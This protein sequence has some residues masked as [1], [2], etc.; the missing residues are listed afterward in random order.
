ML[1]KVRNR[2]GL[3]AAVEPYDASSQGRFHMVRVEYTEADG[4]P[5]DNV[6]WEVEQDTTLLEPHALPKVSGDPAMT[7][8]E[9]DAFQHAIRWSALT[10]FLDPAGSG[11]RSETIFASPFFGAVQVDD[12]QLVPLAK[13][14]TMP[15]VSLLLAD[16]VGLGKTIEAGLILTE[17]LLRRRVRRVLILT[18]ASLTQQWQQEM[19]DRFA[20]SF[21]IID[22]NET[23][24]LQK[25]LG[26][27]ANP[28]RTFPRVICSYHYLRQPDVREQ[29]LATCRQAQVSAQ[30]PWDLL[31]VDE[32][33]NLMPANFGDDS[34]LAR[35]LR[36][37]SPLFEH[38]LFLTATP[39]NGH[40]RCFSGLLEMLDPVR[41]TQVNEFQPAEQERM[42]Q[43]VVRRL[44]RE[45][46]EIDDTLG[47]P[48]RFAERFPKPLPLYFSREERALSDAVEE[49]RKAVRSLVASSA[50]SEQ[51][52]GRFAI[53][54]LS[55]RLLSSPTTFA[56]SWHRMKEGA[57]QGAS[58]TA[59]AVEAARRAAEEDL[60]DDPELE[61]RAHH[62]VRVIGE[63][64]RPFLDALTPQVTAIDQA[65]QNLNLH[66]PGTLPKT[67]C[68]FDRLLLLIEEQLRQ[69]QGWRKDERL[70]VF[71]EY[72]T[73]LDY[74]EKRLRQKFPDHE[75][76]IRVLYG[77]K[78]RMGRSNRDAVIRA[79]NDPEDPVRILVA[80]DVASEG[81]NLQES[82]RLLMHYEVPWNPSR[83]EQRNGR[84]DR[85]GQAKDVL[86]YHFTS[87]DSADLK[88]IEEVVRKIHEIREDLG[89]VGQIFD[90]AFERRFLEMEDAGH[91]L[92]Q[93]D[94]DVRVVRTKTS[95]GRTREEQTAE[96][97]A[98]RLTVLAEHVDL[99]PANLQ[100]TL[101]VALGA[102]H[103]Y[104]RLDGDGCRSKLVH[105]IP[106]DWQAIVDD[107]LRLPTDT[108]ARGALPALAFDPGC[109]VQ[110]RNG[111]PVFR[112]AKDT[113]LLHL[114][115][116]LL[117]F[118]LARFA[119]LRFPGSEEAWSAS[120][121]T[122]RS[123]P[124]P[125]GADAL[126]LL[127]TEELA[128]NDL[129]EPFH[130]WIRTFQI[131]IAKGHL[132]D[133]LPYAPP[134]LH[135]TPLRGIAQSRIPEARATWDEIELDVRDF[136]K[137]REAALFNQ[138]QTAL[139]IALKEALDEQRTSF[140]E[141]IREVE[142]AKSETTIAR[143]QRER[144]DLLAELRQRSLL[145]EI[146]REQELRLR[147][148]EE[149]IRRRT[150]H[151]DDL[152]VV[153]R[154]EQERILEQLIPRRYQLRLAQVFPVAV[155]LRFPE[156]KSHGL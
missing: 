17:L 135:Q 88:F 80:T 21:D 1:A 109:F 57:T 14:L 134:G 16:D 5:E 50:K 44:K 53:E 140:R 40:T 46:N 74:L 67:D 43:V 133:A 123:G 29:F 79:F 97:Q 112:P 96:E 6:L 93:L 121:W 102:G 87:E 72:K 65:L 149:E 115:H 151:Y 148:L 101:E 129:R 73:T 41:F 125:A 90:A 42:R 26:M 126:L 39:H 69:G 152:L 85:H 63:W 103:G 36:I 142:K 78:S 24:A 13:A 62:A 156:G 154:R 35:T 113:T 150:S 141:R 143:L 81:L 60:D 119:R 30:L 11:A 91:L 84:L 15:R 9:F 86:V 147:D 132:M 58:G 108:A 51:L 137:S 61:S 130:H 4:V 55:K 8:R 22:R 32:A 10:P 99:T 20:L 31:I 139:K 49:F 146:E 52:A 66:R 95:L 45:I 107:S 128:V 104:P 155:E 47:R 75:D 68:R 105:P 100:N 48:R 106:Y 92:S 144:D 54:V 3:V 94:H 145:S 127:T 122:V 76:S 37:L 82:A 7:G 59:A 124:V 64:L 114:G 33:H 116:P 153:L 56:E 89:S 38:K 83:L 110:T 27:D 23:H 19:K 34:E 25:R 118:A 77:G 117:H 131:P 111:R 2:R 136:L 70:I 98:R 138:L 18:P 28:W 71:T 120:R 12:F